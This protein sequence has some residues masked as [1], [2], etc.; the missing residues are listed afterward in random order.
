[1]TKIR[2]KRTNI[3]EKG[4]TESSLEKDLPDTI[5]IKDN[6]TLPVSFEVLGVVTSL[7]TISVSAVHP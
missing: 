2:A 5:V 4:G 6:V 1:L 7:Y 3:L